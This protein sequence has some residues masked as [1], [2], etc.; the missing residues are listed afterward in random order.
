MDQKDGVTSCYAET[1]SSKP[2]SNTGHHTKSN[3][4]QLESD[5]LIAIYAFF[6]Q[7]SKKDDPLGEFSNQVYSEAAAAVRLFHKIHMPPKKTYKRLWDDYRKKPESFPEVQEC[8]LFVEESMSHCGCSCP[9]SA[10]ERKERQECSRKLIE[11]DTMAICFTGCFILKLGAS[12][13]KT[14][15][16]RYQQ[17]GG[18]ERILIYTA[19]HSEAGILGPYFFDVAE[20]QDGISAEDYRK[21]LQTKLIPE[22]E[23]KLCPE[24]FKKVIFQQKGLDYQENPVTMSYLRSV[25]GGQ[26]DF[27][28]YSN[29]L[30]RT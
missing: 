17:T 13:K 29:T 27:A 19:I 10:E 23:A 26:A 1:K 16:G 14:A 6:Q 9:S 22:L 24:S 11:I 30:A 28:K 5:Q 12:V 21:L 15:C 7:S 18:R 4:N 3:L 2:D 25:F 8:L 20:G